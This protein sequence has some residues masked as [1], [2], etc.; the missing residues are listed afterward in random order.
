[1]ISERPTST[2][3]VPAAPGFS[4]IE[5]CFVDDP[6][7]IEKGDEAIDDLIRVVPVITWQIDLYGDDRPLAERYWR[8]VIAIT[9]E[10]GAAKDEAAIEFPN[11][12][13]QDG[14]GTVYLNRFDYARR[15]LETRALEMVDAVDAGKEG[16]DDSA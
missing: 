8:H 9:P 4:E 11:G 12:E 5:V 15:I 6:H 13:V 2:T 3:V 16:T 14:H 10:S 7:L 1:V